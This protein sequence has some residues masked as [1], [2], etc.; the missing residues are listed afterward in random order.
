MKKLLSSFAISSIILTMASCSN[1]IEQTFEKSSDNFNCNKESAIATAALNARDFFFAPESR[2]AS[3]SVDKIN[4]IT[5]R[6]S[7]SNAEDTL[8]YVVNFAD[9]KG[10]AI[11]SAVDKDDPVYA[12]TDCGQYTPDG[13]NVTGVED[14]IQRAKT[15]MKSNQDSLIAVKPTD[16]SHLL[17]VDI[18]EDTLKHVNIPAKV[19]THWGQTGFFAK[20]CPHYSAST[21][22]GATGCVITAVAM[23]MSYYGYPYSIK[24]DFDGDTSRL[25]MKLMWNEINKHIVTKHNCGTE[26]IGLCLATAETHDVIA[27]LMR[28]LGHLVNADYRISNTGFA[29]TGA[30]AADAAYLFNKYGYEFNGYYQFK[31]TNDSKL[32]DDYLLFMFASDSSGNFLSHCFIVDGCR[33]LTVKKTEKIYDTERIPW[34]LISEKD[35]GTYTNNY[36]HVNWGWDGEADGYYRD[37]VFNTKKIIESD[38]PPKSIAGPDSTS[39]DVINYATVRKQ[40]LNID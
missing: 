27:K 37:N 18:E 13:E 23:V 16:P 19:K 17:Y 35:L 7:R 5:S 26:N 15:L 36:M 4:Y 6:S 21:N 34:L 29:Y 1:D 32:A 38:F 31:G 39:Y 20:Y 10:F 24:I 30:S 25:P 33:K 40:I 2:D 11:L 12:V 14:Y 9:N 22:K 3:V 28:Q 8:I